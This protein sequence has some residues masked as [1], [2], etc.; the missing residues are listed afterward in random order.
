[1][2]PL[3]SRSDVYSFDKKQHQ[4]KLDIS[5][6]VKNI[7]FVVKYGDRTYPSNSINRDTWKI[8]WMY[9]FCP[10]APCVICW[11]SKV[12]EELRTKETFVAK[13]PFFCKDNRRQIYEHGV[14]RI[15]SALDDDKHVTAYKIAEMFFDDVELRRRMPDLGVM[16]TPALV[17]DAYK[18]GVEDWD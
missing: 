7:D 16:P 4:V 9:V 2:K 14:M 10:C 5:D 12:H 3:H 8:L 18:L 1:M 17:M 11:C 13:I 6:A 15:Q